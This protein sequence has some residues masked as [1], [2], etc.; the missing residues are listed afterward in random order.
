MGLAGAAQRVEFRNMVLRRPVFAL[1]ALPF[2]LAIPDVRSAALG[3]VEWMR[4]GF[5]VL[6][7][8]AANFVSGCF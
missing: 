8:D 1:A 6:F 5:V 2:A 4:T 7:V 3:A